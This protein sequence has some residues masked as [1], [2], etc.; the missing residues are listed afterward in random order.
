MSFPVPSGKQVC[1]PIN[2]FLES[3]PANIPSPTWWCSTKQCN[4]EKTCLPMVKEKERWLKFFTPS[5][6]TFYFKRHW[7]PFCSV[8][9]P[10]HY[11]CA[12]LEALNLTPYYSLKGKQNTLQRAALSAYRS[13]NL[14]HHI[15][16]HSDVCTRVLHA[17]GLMN[18][19]HNVDL[20]RAMHTLCL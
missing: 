11:P 4:C 3:F 10:G 8:H 19:Y 18:L 9:S 15:F 13:T 7:F 6:C 12:R 16:N 20:Y 14:T 2:K 1:S 5:F 17:L